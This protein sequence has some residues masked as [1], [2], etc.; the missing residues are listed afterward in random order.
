MGENI[1]GWYRVIDP[2]NPLFGCDVKISDSSAVVSAG[3]SKLHWKIIA[4]RRVDIFV[5]DR[6]FQLIAPEGEDLGLFIDPDHLEESQIQDDVVE[7]TTARP[8]GISLDE[9]EL[10]R[11][12]GLTLNVARYERAVQMALSVN[13]DLLATKTF[14]GDPEF[15]GQH[16]LDMFE[17]G[18]SQDDIVYELKRRD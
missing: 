10:T 14:V 4:M 11:D 6:P 3:G 12:D 13:D 5:G 2:L 16:I 15:V 1:H 17:D 18:A 8:F 7:L 9:G